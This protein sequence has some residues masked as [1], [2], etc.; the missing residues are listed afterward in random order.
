MPHVIY[1][2]PEC[3][4]AG[5]DCCYWFRVERI[6]TNLYSQCIRAWQQRL[7][8]IARCPRCRNFIAFS[9]DA[10]GRADTAPPGS[11]T[12]PDDWYVHAEFMDEHGQLVTIV[13]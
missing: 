3:P 2:V 1:L 4:W 9:I 5:C 13:P 6:D 11:V 10:I 8:L 7:A 12:L